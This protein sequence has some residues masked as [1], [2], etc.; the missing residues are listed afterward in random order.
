MFTQGVCL[1]AAGDALMIGSLA[2]VDIGLI[3]ACEA[4]KLHR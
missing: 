4:L 2:N 3:R 1:L